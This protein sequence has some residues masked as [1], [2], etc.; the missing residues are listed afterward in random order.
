MRM[1][2]GNPPDHSLNSL[3]FSPFYSAS[4]WPQNKKETYFFYKYFHFSIDLPLIEWYNIIKI[5]EGDNRYE[6]VQFI[7]N[8]EES[9]GTG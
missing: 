3:S 4:I 1:G 8:H 5:R 6:K 9:M 7:Q 2:W